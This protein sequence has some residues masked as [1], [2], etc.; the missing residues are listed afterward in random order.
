MIINHN[1]RVKGAELH[2]CSPPKSVL[3][4]PTYS[5][6]KPSRFPK[7]DEP[8]RGLGNNRHY[9]LAELVSSDLSVWCDDKQEYVQIAEGVVVK[10]GDMYVWFSPCDGM[11]DDRF[12]EVKGEFELIFDYLRGLKLKVKA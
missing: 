11:P 3:V 12:Y 8:L 1:V 10:V 4:S 7:W 6:S 5:Y 9:D 2:S